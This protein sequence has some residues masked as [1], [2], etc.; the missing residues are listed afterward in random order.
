MEVVIKAS[1]IK[2]QKVFNDTT[3]FPLTL[4][5]EKDAMSCEDL[6]EYIK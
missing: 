3:V 4:T 6:V 2:E 5:P 1:E